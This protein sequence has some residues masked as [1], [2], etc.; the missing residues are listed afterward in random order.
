MKKIVLLLVVVILLGVVYK[1]SSKRDAATGRRADTE[2]IAVTARPGVV[3]A[4]SNHV[5]AITG[6]GDIYGWGANQEKELGL[7]DV[8]QIPFPTR[9]TAE[10]KW[11]FVHTGTS[12]S[13]AITVD[14][15]LQ[16]RGFDRS[17]YSGVNPG[18][19]LRLAYESIG[20]RTQWAKV[21][22]SWGIGVGLD[23]YEKLW[24]W[25]DRN[26]PA[27][28]PALVYPLRAW[29]DF[30]VAIGKIYAVAS[31][32]TL[33]RAGEASGA[34]SRS[35]RAQDLMQ[36]VKINAPAQLQRVYCRENADQVLALD[37]DL[38]LWGFGSNTYGELGN[39]DGDPYTR[40]EA[41][42]ETAIR[43]LND[44]RWIDIAIGR[45]FTIGIAADGSLWAWG[46]NVS[47]QLGIGD[48]SSRDVPTLV[49]NSRVWV[50]VAAGYSFGAAVTREGELYT[51]GANA[52]GVLGEGGAAAIRNTPTR[53]YGDRHWGGRSMS[54]GARYASP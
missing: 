17:R 21:Q 32:G 23:A 31:D 52:S 53:V 10:T 24:V 47:G 40:S 36:F 48:N 49:D 26:V 5:V 15:E 39:G 44:K 42:P 33:W 4:G 34:V 14:G 27:E 46:N 37:A 16:R 9:L 19:R 41:V 43:Q 3:S 51:W 50:S 29:A 22:E 6:D 13:Y 18:E 8:T 35:P 28:S 11:R 54:A 12:A 20:A 7:S 38:H 1:K 25:N 45:G 30:C 2:S